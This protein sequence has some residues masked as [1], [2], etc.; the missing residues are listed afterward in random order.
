MFY[1]NFH[2][3][4]QGVAELRRQGFDID[5]VVAGASWSEQEK[6]IY[7]ETPD[8]QFVCLRDLASDAQLATL[9]QHAAGLI[10]PSEYEGFGL[11]V[12]EAMTFGTPVIA[13]RTS[14]IPEVAGQAGLLIEPD[15]ATPE[16]L[17][18]C[19]RLLLTDSNLRAD[20]ARRSIEQARKFQLGHDRI[21]DS[22]RLP[23][24]CGLMTRINQA[25]P[26]G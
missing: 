7:G 6:S 10:Y 3:A 19:A 12:L 20:V 15:E 16:A 22:C 11:P 17:A 5:L 4:V 23:S 8:Y 24:A 1:K 14:S 13:L 21:R 26:F 25:S 18:D 9:Y 2:L